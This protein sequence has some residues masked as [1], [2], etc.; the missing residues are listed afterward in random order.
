MRKLKE[1][2]LAVAVVG[3][4]SPAVLADDL[5]TPPW[6][7]ETE[8]TTYQIWDTWDTLGNGVYEAQEFYTSPNAWENPWIY[9]PSAT[10]W[11][12]Y[13]GRDDVLVINDGNPLEIYIQNWPDNPAGSKEIYMQIT[14][15]WDGFIDIP[16]L[17]WPSGYNPDLLVFEDLGNGWFYDQYLWTIDDQSPDFEMFYIWAADLDNLVIDQIIIDTR[18]VPTPASLSLLALGGFAMIRR[19]RR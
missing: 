6:Q 3:I 2:L 8:N 7:R 10:I 12:S 13:D 18:T 17:V 14:Y 4:V 16:E 9:A 11:S 1:L 19:R 5:N 15:H